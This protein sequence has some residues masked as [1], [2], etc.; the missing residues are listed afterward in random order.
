[1]IIISIT[2]EAHEVA[3]ESMDETPLAV[4]EEPLS[5]FANVRVHSPHTYNMR[6]HHEGT[7]YRIESWH[8]LNSEGSH[9]ACMHADVL[10]L[11]GPPLPS[12]VYSFWDSSPGGHLLRH[13][14]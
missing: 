9:H 14:V 4:S 12:L 5:S 3:Q 6:G 8:C 1:M 10:C 11:A 13:E 7:I 2:I